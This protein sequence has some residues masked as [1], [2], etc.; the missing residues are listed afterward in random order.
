MKK[1]SPTLGLGA[2]MMVAGGLGMVGSFLGFVVG[3]VGASME[4]QSKMTDPQR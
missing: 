4:V 3:G 2:R 1:R